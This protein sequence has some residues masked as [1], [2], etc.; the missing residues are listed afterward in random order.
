MPDREFKYMTQFVDTNSTTHSYT[1]N[2]LSPDA[3][4]IYY[5]RC[6]DAATL[7]M[8]KETTVTFSVT[9]T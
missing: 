2:S 7:I 8:S 5:V 6:E 1:L 3:L 9:G 4:Y